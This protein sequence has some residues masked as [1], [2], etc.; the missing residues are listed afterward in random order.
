MRRPL[1]ESDTY[2]SINSIPTVKQKLGY[3]D[4]AAAAVLM[5]LYGCGCYDYYKDA[6]L[7][8]SQQNTLINEMTR[9]ANNRTTIGEV[10]RTLRRYYSGTYGRTFQ[11][12]YTSDFNE[13]IRLLTNGLYMNTAPII[14]IPDG[15]NYYYGV[16]SSIYRSSEDDSEDISII[17]PRTGTCLSY[18]FDEFKAMLF[19]DKYSI[20]WM[21]VFDHDTSNQTIEDL[22]IQYPSEKSHYYGDDDNASQC[23][24][25][26]RYVFNKVKGRTYTSSRPI[27]RTGFGTQLSSS[28]SIDDGVFSGA[29]LTAYVARKYLLGLSTGAYVRLEDI[30]EYRNQEY[31]WHSIAVL[32]TSENG[33]KYYEANVDGN[34]LVRIKERTWANFAQNY[35]LL[36]YVD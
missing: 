9:I 34:G 21:S 27:N 32:E 6:S 29:G 16:V 28:T 10:T 1:Y 25:F 17:D 20:V 12:K 8:D 4:G 31:P 33:I 13:M 14:R 36:F 11:T 15:N 24:G 19:K 23:A 26:A 18:T 3:D 5:A 2:F 35:R 22:K 30:S 7:K